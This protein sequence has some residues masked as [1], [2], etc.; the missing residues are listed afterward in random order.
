MLWF[1]RM[2]AVPEKNLEGLVTIDVTSVSTNSVW[3]ESN[4]FYCFTDCNKLMQDQ[5]S[6]FESFANKTLDASLRWE[7]S[8]CT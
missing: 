2:I 6:Q 5:G 8:M 3:E 7:V 4:A 1:F